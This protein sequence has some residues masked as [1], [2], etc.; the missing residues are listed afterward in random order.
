MALWNVA[1][2]VGGGLIGPLAIDG[3]A[4]FSDWHSTFYFPALIALLIAIL[5]YILL[6][7]TPQSVGLPPIEEFKADYPKNYDRTQEQE[8]SAKK[9]FTKYILPNK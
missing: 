5:T 4:I 6:R 1:H 9:I 2:N 3:I 7:D 8:F